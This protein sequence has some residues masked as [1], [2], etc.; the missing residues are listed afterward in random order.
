MLHILHPMKILTNT[1]IR[2]RIKIE[3]LPFPPLYWCTEIVNTL[4]LIVQCN[5]FHFTSDHSNLAGHSGSF[6][7]PRR[8]PP[9][10]LAQPQLVPH[11]PPHPTHPQ[12]QVPLSLPPHF[13]F[14]WITHNWDQTVW[15]FAPGFFCLAQSQWDVFIL[16]HV[17]IVRS[18]FN[19]V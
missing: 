5:N 19:T 9:M 7:H 10:S 16:L 15:T 13:P 4:I 2:L 11:Y 6:Q 3:P 1:P 8:F 17:S 18:L 12:P 14:S